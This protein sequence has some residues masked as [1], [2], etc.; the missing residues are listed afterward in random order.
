[1]QNLKEPLLADYSNKDEL[2]ERKRQIRRKQPHLGYIFQFMF[3]SLLCLQ[4]FSGK[5][6]FTR[7]PEL[8]PLQLIVIRTFFSMMFY[9]ILIN[10]NVKEVLYTSIPRENVKNL[11]LRC[12]QGVVMFPLLMI[13]V[14]YLPLVFIAL[15]SNMA[16]LFT[17]LLSYLIIREKLK[18]LDISVLLISFVGVIILITGAPDTKNEPQQNQI[19]I[20]LMTVLFFAIPIMGSIN[21][22]NQ[23][24]MRDFNDFTTGTYVNLI[25]LVLFVPY[26]YIFEDGLIIMNRFEYY[27]YLQFILLGGTS[28]CIGLARK[29]ALQ[30]LEPGKLGGI[31]FFQSIIQ[32]M[33]D[34]LFFGFAFAFQQLIGIVIIFTANIVK[35]IIWI[36]KMR[37][38]KQLPSKI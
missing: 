4:Q 29:R 2:L 20:G 33:I 24:S 3:I 36:R 30:Y 27:D 7:I 38:E 15:A 17:A 22:I 37:N 1:M 23:H 21:S 5:I 35:M 25:L 26:I 6:L 28:V 10:V 18:P 16:P 31:N 9:A 8:S 13:A 19:G 32:L 34:I 12:V 11:I 14:K